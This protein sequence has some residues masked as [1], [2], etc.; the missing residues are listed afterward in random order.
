MKKDKKSIV[1]RGY[2]STFNISRELRLQ[3]PVAI[4]QGD[5]KT[6]KRVSKWI[7]ENPLALWELL[8]TKSAPGKSITLVRTAFA[9]LKKVIRENHP[10]AYEENEKK[11]QAHMET[12]RK[13]KAV[14]KIKTLL[15]GDNPPDELP[16]L[17]KGE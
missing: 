6:V 2:T 8:H 15:D 7:E 10:E 3:D 5:R 13:Y 11:R 1:K 17:K 16:R 14:M 4:T 9:E 12:R